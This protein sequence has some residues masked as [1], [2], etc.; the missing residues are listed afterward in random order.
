ARGG[1]RGLPWETS[2]CRRRWYGPTETRHVNSPAGNRRQ[3]PAGAGQ[4]ER[5][6]ASS[7]FAVYR[8]DISGMLNA[9]TTVHILGTQSLKVYPEASRSKPNCGWP[10]H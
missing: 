5:P 9:A 10:E 6:E 1:V 8:K 3:R 7:S 4:S 2:T